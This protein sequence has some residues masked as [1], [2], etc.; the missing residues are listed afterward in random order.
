[1]KFLVSNSFPARELL[2]ITQWV[3]RTSVSAEV[4]A[5]LILRTWQCEQLKA[6]ALLEF[7][8]GLGVKDPALPLLWLEVPSLAP[9]L[10][11]AAW[12]LPPPPKKGKKLALST[13][14]ARGLGAF[15]PF[16]TALISSE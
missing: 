10:L 16:L 15:S 9:K 11:K 5:L 14:T 2:N 4:C 1:M 3:H 7:P 6:H 12:G 13:L 8:G